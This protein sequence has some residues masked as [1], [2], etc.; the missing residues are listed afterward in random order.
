MMFLS[1][2]L[3]LLGLPSSL[4]VGRSSG[5]PPRT[6]RTGVSDVMIGFFMISCIDV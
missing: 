4:R 5:I 6:A 1:S 3:V 2:L